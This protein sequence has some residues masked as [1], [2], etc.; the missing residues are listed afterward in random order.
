MIA[1][2][3]V[4]A[5]LMNNY[6]TSTRVEE[7]GRVQVVGV[8]FAP[9]TEVCVTISRKRQENVEPT[10]PDDVAL[11]AARGHL[12]ELFQSIKGFRNTPRISR[13]ELYERRRV[14]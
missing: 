2:Q 6:E 7:H 8:P 10:N 12:R 9:G 1:V 11:A 4:E 13:E 14:H 5:L 3:R